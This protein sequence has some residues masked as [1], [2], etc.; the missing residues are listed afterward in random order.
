M[1]VVRWGAEG[2][3]LPRFSANVVF[4]PNGF[5]ACAD[6]EAPVFF[7][8]SRAL[9]VATDVVLIQGVTKA[10][11][12]DLAHPRTF[13]ILK[14]RAGLKVTLE[15]AVDPA[16]LNGSR[17]G[18]VLFIPRGL[19]TSADF[20]LVKAE[21]EVLVSVDEVTGFSAVVKQTGAVDGFFRMECMGL[22]HTG[23]GM[24]VPRSSGSISTTSKRNKLPYLAG[25]K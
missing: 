4:S 1:A 24:A 19:D 20:T 10:L 15:A 17:W 12:V 8:S 23:V 9:S 7:C 18:A 2:T 14:H 3:F 22:L 25:K 5:F 16:A 21:I 13:F 6:L 11:G